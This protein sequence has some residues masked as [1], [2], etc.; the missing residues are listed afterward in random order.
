MD[1]TARGTYAK[2]GTK[3]GPRGMAL[4][5]TFKL[6]PPQRHGA[7]LWM[8]AQFVA[9]RSQQ[10]RNLMSQYYLDFLR[11]STWKLYQKRNRTTLV[12]N[13]L[14]TLEMET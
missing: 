4:S 5:A 12:G 11:R 2:D 13:Y 10:A 9:F 6:W 3:V 14:R 7:V 1:E 8:L